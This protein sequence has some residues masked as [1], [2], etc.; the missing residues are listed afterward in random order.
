MHHSMRVLAGLLALLVLLAACA[1]QPA[2]P[3]PEAPT[4]VAMADAPAADAAAFDIANWDSVLEAARGTTVNWYVWGGSESINNYID[5]FYGQALAERYGITLNRVP[6]S[7]TVVAVDQLL[8]EKEA[9]IDTGSI[10]LIWINGEN[11]ASLKQAEMLYDGWARSTPNAALVDWE[12]PAL[13]LD[14]GVPIEELESPW[15]SAQFQLIYDEARI[16]AD[17]LPRSYAEFAAWA[18][19]N[20]GRATYI[21]PGPGAF[22]GTRFV[23]GALFEMSGGA[24]QWGAFDQELWDQWAPELWAFLNELE[25]CLWRAGETYPADENEL[26]SLFANQEVDFS[27]TQAIAGAG[28][29]IS[30][31]LV[32]ETARAFVFDDYMIGDYNYVAIPRNGP[33]K[34]AALVLANL[35]LEPEFQ[36]AQ[37]LP[38]NGFGLGYGIDVRKVEDPADRALLEAAIEQLG[39]A[40]TDPVDLINALVADSA[41]EYQSLVE[42]GWRQN[43]LIGD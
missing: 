11:F 33:N 40:A 9:G 34:A 25:A 17:E 21:A 4:E 31:G 43:V 10:D 23:K 2:A 12:N 41:P 15:S 14:F 28:A 8:S 16:S 13:Y 42:E 19:A 36:A 1:G 32:P 30:D 22:Q 3:A 7:D 29:L 35:L 38:E 24:E 37:V 6:L 18:C 27:I 39:P 20:P 5:T 26:H